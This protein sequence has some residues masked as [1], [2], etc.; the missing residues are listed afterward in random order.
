MSEPPEVSFRDKV[1]SL[2]F[3]SGGLPSRPKVT[4]GRQHPETG[5]PYKRTEDEGSIVTEHNTRDD[6]VDGTAKVDTIR[7][8]SR[9]LAARRAAAERRREASDGG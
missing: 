3:I 9:E 8:S 7:V 4:E 5:R 6:R 1:R 2:S